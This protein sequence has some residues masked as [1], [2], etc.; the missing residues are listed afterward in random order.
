V[1]ALFNAY[2]LFRLLTFNPTDSL[3]HQDRA[4]DKLRTAIEIWGVASPC[5]RR[6]RV[7]CRAPSRLRPA[8]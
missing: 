8:R 3:E 6:Y 4:V 5:W 2:T 1:K 7:R